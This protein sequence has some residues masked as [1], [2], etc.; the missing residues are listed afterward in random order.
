MAAVDPGTGEREELHRSPHAFFGL[1]GSEG[2]QRVFL[3]ADW[4]ADD[5]RARA[6]CTLTEYREFR[7]IDSFAITLKQFRPYLYDAKL[8]A[9][10]RYWILAFASP[11]GFLEADR[12]TLYTVWVVSRGGG[13]RAQVMEAR[14]NTTFGIAPFA[15]QDRPMFSCLQGGTPPVLSIHEIGR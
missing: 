15:Y 12:G 1:A 4:K 9:T 14:R 5:T 7:K 6:E 3:G 11:P 10:G 8:D 2:G 13:R